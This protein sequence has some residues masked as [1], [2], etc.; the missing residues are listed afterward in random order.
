[1]ADDDTYGIAEQTRSRQGT[2]AF[3]AKSITAEA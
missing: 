3:H 1:M 2:A